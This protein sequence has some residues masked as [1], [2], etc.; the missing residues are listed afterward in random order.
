MHPD[1]KSTAARERRAIVWMATVGIAA[2]MLIEA[3][4]WARTSALEREAAPAI[5]D[6]IDRINADGPESVRGRLGSEPSYAIERRKTFHG[7]FDHE[8]VLSDIRFSH[9]ETNPTG[10]FVPMSFFIADGTLADKDVAL[11]VAISDQELVHWNIRSF[12][13]SLLTES[14][15]AEICR[16]ELS[17]E[18][19]N[20]DGFDPPWIAYP[21]TARFSTDWLSPE[22]R[23]FI[24]SFGKWWSQI[25]D[26]DREAYSQANHPPGEWANWYRNLTANWTDHDFCDA[27]EPDT[28]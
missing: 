26:S 27:D 10:V 24:V 14:M 1:E 25:D 3:S 15:G 7:L 2:I 17:Y 18:V 9:S 4:L 13:E 8:F 20:E 22:R 12:D 16:D 5:T 28:L 19:E 21:E 6:V 23:V 11:D